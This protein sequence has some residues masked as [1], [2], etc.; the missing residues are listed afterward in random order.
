MH[1]VSP[2]VKTLTAAADARPTTSRFATPSLAPQCHP[3]RSPP[4]LSIPQPK[5][6]SAEWEPSYLGWGPTNV[7]LLFAVLAVI[8]LPHLMIT[9]WFEHSVTTN[10]P[11]SV[12]S[13]R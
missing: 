2:L 12:T 8:A 11:R 4:S 13:R 1:P 9:S 6:R 3:K 7:R 5:P 10:V